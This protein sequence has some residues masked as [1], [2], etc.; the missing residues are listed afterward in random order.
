MKHLKRFVRLLGR[1]TT[2]ALVTTLLKVVITVPL[3]ILGNHVPVLAPS[4]PF[5]IAL[6]IGIALIVWEKQKPFWKVERTRHEP[7]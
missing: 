2:T 1:I 3:V 4:L 7:V 6:I 5:H